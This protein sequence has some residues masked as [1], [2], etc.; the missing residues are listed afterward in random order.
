[1]GDA[2]DKG[3]DGHDVRT[4]DGHVQVLLSRELNSTH[5]VMKRRIQLL[6]RRLRQGGDTTRLERDLTASETELAWLTT[7]FERI[8]RGNG[9]N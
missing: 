4:D 6:R 5:I 3:E 2:H 7:I 8:P 9:G 1:M